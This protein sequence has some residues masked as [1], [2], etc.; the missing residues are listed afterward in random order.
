MK[1]RG[2]HERPQEAQGGARALLWARPLL[3]AA[4]SLMVAQPGCGS[5]PSAPCARQHQRTPSLPE[6]ARPPL[7]V[8]G[9][10]HLEGL[11]PALERRARLLYERAEDEGIQL[12]FISGYRPYKERERRAGSSKRS[13]SLASWHNFGLAFDVNLQ[14]RAGMGDALKHLSE[15]AP[16]WERVGALAADLGL[17]WGKSWGKEEL[18]HFEWHPGHPDAIR[19]PTLNALKREAAGGDL[20]GGYKGVWGNIRDRAPTRAEE[21]SR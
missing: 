15:D 3:T 16:R 5:R 19:A 12:R 20:R 10:E 1:R 7:Q 2:T 11:H 18:F 8:R 14:G 6:P 17:I 13:P 21:Q 9:G 4:L